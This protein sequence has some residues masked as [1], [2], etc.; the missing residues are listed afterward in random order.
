MRVGWCDCCGAN[1][2]ATKKRWSWGFALLGGIGLYGLYRWI[3][4][5]RNKCVMCYTILIKK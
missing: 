4:V 2:V 1:R 3:F 5:R